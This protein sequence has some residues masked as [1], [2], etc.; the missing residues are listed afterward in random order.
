MV[1]LILLTVN[2][3]SSID[4]L[5]SSK[6]SSNRRSNSRKRESGTVEAEGAMVPHLLAV[7]LIAKL[8]HDVPLSVV[9]LHH[10]SLDSERHHRCVSRLKQHHRQES[11]GKKGTTEQ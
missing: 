7:V 5:Q 10:K 1:A 6:S 8:L 2:P 9:D 4:P 3:E 11:A